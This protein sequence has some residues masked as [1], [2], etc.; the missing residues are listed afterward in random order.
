MGYTITQL[1][2]HLGCLD[3]LAAAMDRGA[4][5]AECVSVIESCT[6]V[7]GGNGIFGDDYELSRRKEMKSSLMIFE[8]LFL[9]PKDVDA[10]E[11]RMVQ[12]A[13]GGYIKEKPK[14]IQIT[15]D[16]P[17]YLAGGVACLFV[18]YAASGGISLH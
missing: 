17:I 9:S 10:E 13:G 1:R 16:D 5:V 14:F 6:N 3:T 11:D 7:R 8:K 4:S 12:G 2:L 15:G 18:A